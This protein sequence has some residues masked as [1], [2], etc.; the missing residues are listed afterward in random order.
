MA[1]TKMKPVHSHLRYLVGYVTDE[2]KTVNPDL[3]DILSE[4]SYISDDWKTEQR[5]YVD[6]INCSPNTAYQAMCDSLKASG[7]PTRVLAYHAI[8][9]FKPGEVSAK[10]AH[11]IGMKLAKELWCDKFVVLVAT[12]LNKAHFHNHFLLCSTSYKDGSRYHACTATYW[13]MRNASDRLCLEYGLYVPQS[14]YGHG[15]AYTERMDELHGKPTLSSIM[16]ADVD[17]AISQSM[18]MRHFFMALDALGYEVKHGKYLAIRGK[19]AERFRRLKTLGEDYT[20]AAI[21]RRIM[22][23]QHRI[24]PYSEHY[25][26]LGSIRYRGAFKN[27]PRLSGLRALYFHYL[28]RM[29]ILPQQKNSGRRAHPL[30]Q[31]D[32]IKL[33]KIIE[34]NAFLRRCRIDTVEELS[35]HKHSVQQE[36]SFMDTARTQLRVRLKRV[37]PEDVRQQTKEEIYAITQQMRVLRREDKMCDA[38]AERS[39]NMRDK[40]CKVNHF[41]DRKALSNTAQHYH[42][43]R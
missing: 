29:C 30:L 40:L 13:D 3:V 23:N 16:R 19:G 6:G 18:V 8:Q 14:P 15:K 17:L 20:E 38:I 2:E 28:Y 33:D 37:L 7:K 31:E 9:S 22:E 41:I 24:A 21:M 27:R 5:Y 32:I 26:K 1:V 12:H 39:E 36:L 10:T 4:I 43:T 42:D 11:E 35:E 25:R 34:Q